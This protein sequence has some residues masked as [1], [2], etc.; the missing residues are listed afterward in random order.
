MIVDALGIDMG[1]TTVVGRRF[2]AGGGMEEEEVGI[3]EVVTNCCLGTPILE[4]VGFCV[5]FSLLENEE[6]D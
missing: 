6:V 4:E 3:V 5:M 2:E 1:V